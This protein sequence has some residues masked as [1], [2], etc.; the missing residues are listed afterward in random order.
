M[1]QQRERIEAD[2]RGLLEGEVRCDDLFTQMYA[3]DASLY[4]LRPLAIVRPRSTADVVA[5]VRYA[6]EHSLP[7]HA[8]GAGT[9]LAG[10]SLGPGIMVDF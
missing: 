4:E 2:L 1:D 5:T 7:I 9:G 8:R 10:E 3:S 6:A